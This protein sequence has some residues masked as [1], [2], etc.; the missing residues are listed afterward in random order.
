MPAFA[1]PLRT[2]GAGVSCLAAAP[3]PAVAIA[4]AMAS[5]CIALTIKGGPPQ[6]SLIPQ[7]CFPIPLAGLQTQDLFS[8]TQRGPAAFACCACASEL[9]GKAAFMGAVRERSEV[10]EAPSTPVICRYNGVAVALGVASLD[11]DVRRKV[12]CVNGCGAGEIKSRARQVRFA[13]DI[14]GST[15]RKTWPRLNVGAGGVTCPKRYKCIETV[16]EVCWACTSIA[17]R[18]RNNPIAGSSPGCTLCLHEER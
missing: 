14:A 10:N 3:A 18:T 7:A 12:D 8:R 17:N 9:N 13:S 11:E 5:G 4:I 16:W 6:R 2:A 15:S 1:P